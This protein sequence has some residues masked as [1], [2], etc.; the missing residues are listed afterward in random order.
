[1]EFKVSGFDKAPVFAA[2]LVQA[3]GLG[4]INWGKL[5]QGLD[6]ILHNLNRRDNT[7]WFSEIPNTSFEAK[8]RLFKQ[9]F[10]K[11][12]RF[13]HMKSKVHRMFVSLS[14]ANK[15]RQIFYPRCGAGLR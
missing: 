3:H 7:G 4:V 1:M 9:W 14:K 2:D 6:M 8:R 5:E 10:V 12:P 15:H 11:E 13:K